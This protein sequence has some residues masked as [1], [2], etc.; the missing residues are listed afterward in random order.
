LLFTFGFTKAQ[1][2]NCIVTVDPE[3]ERNQSTS[4]KTLQTSISE[5][6]N[7]TDWTGKSKTKI[8]C[9]M[10]I[11]VSANSSDQFTATI[12]VQSSRPIL[13]RRIRLLY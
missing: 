10:Y 5:F 3:T 8:N 7:K 11:T 4:F 13:I 9:S 12:Q 1:Q 6:V 2:L